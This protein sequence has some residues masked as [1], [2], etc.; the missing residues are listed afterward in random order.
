MMTKTTNQTTHHIPGST[1]G[2]DGD[3]SQPDFGIS[4][5]FP[6]TTSEFSTSAGLFGAATGG[7]SAS[8]MLQS[9]YLTESGDTA[10]ISVNDLHQGQLGDCFLISP[11]GEIAM[12]NPSWI[13]NMIHQN[14][15]GTSTVTL[16]TASN[17]QLPTY[18]TTQFSATQITVADNFASYTVNSGA[19]QDVVGNVKE[20]WPQV[21]EKAVASLDGGYNVINNGGYPIVAMEELT[22]HS[23]TSIGA[24]G[25]TLSELQSFINAGD[26]ITMDTSSNSNLPYG[27]VSGHSYM[28]EKLT[29]SGGTPMVQ[30]GNP[31]GMD[32][33]SLIPVAQIT[34]GSSGLVQVDIGKV[35]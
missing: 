7:T 35:G 33:P 25:M 11:I 15:N 14:T 9:L 34:A 32:Q 18:G 27:L 13:Q 29:T 19:S 5:I 21:I 24:S 26:L 20:I 8:T 28:F 17:G 2:I 10:S 4:A 16:Y 22:G 12:H 1:P 23:A 30:L 6:G 3:G 31:W